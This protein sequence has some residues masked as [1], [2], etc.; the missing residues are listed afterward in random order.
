MYD[1]NLLIIYVIYGSMVWLALSLWI[2]KKSF[3]GESL[4]TEREYAKKQYKKIKKDKSI[5]KK[6]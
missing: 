6:R 2:L 5:F 1:K 4:A 3:E